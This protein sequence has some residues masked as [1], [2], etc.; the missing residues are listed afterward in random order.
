MAGKK[1]ELV[2]RPR[3]KNEFEI[4]FAT[5]HAAKGWRDLVASIRNPMAE[6]WD[7]LTVTPLLTTPTN[8]RLK[9]ELVSFTIMGRRMIGG[10][11]NLLR[12]GLLESG[13]ML[14]RTLCSSSRSI[15]IILMRRSNPSLGSPSIWGSYPRGAHVPRSISEGCNVCMISGWGASGSSMLSNKR[16][17][18]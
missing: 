3:K 16:A 10:N 5:T 18:L 15:P 9:G 13:F 11:I 6:T 8:Y 1:S 17:A 7:F 2:P 12:K 4:H 14:R